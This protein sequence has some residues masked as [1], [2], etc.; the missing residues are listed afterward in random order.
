MLQIIIYITACYRL[1]FRNKMLIQLEYNFSFSF[2]RILDPNAFLLTYK[3]MIAFMR[4][5]GWKSTL[6]EFAGGQSSCLVQVAYPVG[7]L[8]ATAYVIFVSYLGERLEVQFLRNSLAEH[9]GGDGE[10]HLRSHVLVDDFVGYADLLQLPVTQTPRDFEALL[11]DLTTNTA[12]LT[13]R[14]RA[15]VKDFHGTLRVVLLEDVYS[16]FYLITKVTWFNHFWLV[17]SLMESAVFFKLDD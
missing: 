12:L 6:S 1:F 4:N 10:S 14:I 9:R 2:E 5:P 17:I 15:Y 8:L 3:R 16:R 11:H 13:I 7:H